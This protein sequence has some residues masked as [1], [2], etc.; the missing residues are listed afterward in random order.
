M[1]D[2][3]GEKTLRKHVYKSDGKIM[4]FGLGIPPYT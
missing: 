3:N 2:M 1:F 4:C